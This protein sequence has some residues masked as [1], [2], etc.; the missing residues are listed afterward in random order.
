MGTT[1]LGLDDQNHT[2][3]QIGTDQRELNELI[4]PLPKLSVTPTFG[5]D[6]ISLSM[7]KEHLETAF[8]LTPN[9]KWGN[10]ACRAPNRL[11]KYCSYVSKL[12]VILLV[13]IHK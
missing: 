2:C 13:A 1:V 9:E 12:P 11:V 10:P 6:N 4:C 7:T 8:Y 5:L 3:V